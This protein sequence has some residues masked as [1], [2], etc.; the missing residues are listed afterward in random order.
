[1]ED[2]SEGKKINLPSEGKKNKFTY[3]T[4]PS[5]FWKKIMFSYFHKG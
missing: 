5:R 2:L 3:L 4:L 1:M